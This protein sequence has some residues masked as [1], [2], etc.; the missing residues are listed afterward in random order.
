MERRQLGRGSIVVPENHCHPPATPAPVARGSSQTAPPLDRLRERL[1][2][3]EWVKGAV[4]YDEDLHFST[5]YLRASCVPHTGRLY[6]G[7]T[8]LVAIYEGFNEHYYLLKDECRDTAV[9]LVRK[10]LRRPEWLPCVIQE[11]I[12]LSDRL[13][14]VFDPRTFPE[15]LARFSD[16][17]LLTL[18]QRHA[19]AQ[20]AL[21]RYARLPE[22]L[23]RGVSYFS[24]YLLDH[25]RQHGMSAAAADETFAVLSQP[26][27]PSVLAQEMLEFEEI[28]AAARAAGSE[29]RAERS[30]RVRMF[31]SPDL[32]QRLHAHQQKW[33]F[34]TYH[35][36]G[37]RELATV[38]Q[39]V[40]R[41][42][43][44][45]H[46]P[47]SNGATGLGGRYEA[48]R[49]ARDEALARLDLDPGHRALFEVYADIGAAKLHRRYAQLRNFYYLDLLLAEIANRLG[50]SEWTVRC[51]LPEEVAA[52]LRAGRLVNP[53]IAERTGGCVFAV[54]DGEEL[55]V[56]GS[57]ATQLAGLVRA[58]VRGPQSGATL[59]GVVACRGTAVGPCKVVIRA[60]DHH[61]DF[62]DGAIIVSESTD[63]DLVGLLRRAGGVLTEQGGV[64]S[65]AAIICRELNIPTIIGIDG[66]LD[67]LH[68]GDVVRVD[69]EQGIVTPL[70]NGSCP[71]DQLGD[72]H[73]PEVIG[74][75]AYNLGVVRSLGFAVPEFIA[76]PADRARQ[77]T[78]SA[79]GEG[80]RQLAGVVKQLHL[81]AHDKLALRSSAAD[82]DSANGSL[83]GS[84]RSL[85]NI[86]PRFLSS[87]LCEF[88]KNNSQRN[89]EAGY[90]GAVI[91]QRMIAADYAGVCL[92]RDPRTGQRDAVILELLAGGNEA[93]TS[94]E[95]LPDRLVVDRLT[96]D[97]L[98]EE[99]RCPGL[100]H[101]DIDLAGMVQ[102]F[103]TLEAR[104]GQALDIEWAVA[105]RKLYILQARPIVG[106][107]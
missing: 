94:G 67:R 51:M 101:A 90:R 82:E 47:A 75:K 32:V 85:L 102:H 48:A 5:F 62:P 17:A 1:Q 71:P 42:A 96:G 98:E 81:G 41:L 21:Y 15:R 19:V 60:D 97:I 11:I 77:L 36:Y 66:L 61:E 35:G 59:R 89:G 93:L 91:I 7:Y 58:Q 23:D 72:L 3:Q 80:A 88:L 65:H 30:S 78:E 54:I 12:R 28:V 76:L 46:D 25:L 18:Y 26:L 33:Q 57:D 2:N 87:A 16:P 92:T 63:P 20:R 34:L 39:Y 43:Q 22:A 37:R 70:A 29:T 14:R 95:A 40:E 55:V 10:A 56:A 106:G 74:A 104:F 100:E 8:S 99:R 9:A 13:T 38:G 84:Y 50:V 69:A 107:R 4:N 45:L 6:R 49:Q 86:E 105:G 44:R 52:S 73:T 79:D 103:L 31:L 83:A 27:G 64:T 68:D 24:S 53:R